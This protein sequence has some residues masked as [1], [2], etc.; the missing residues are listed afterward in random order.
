[1]GRDGILNYADEVVKR[2]VSDAARYAPEER[3][4]ALVARL[5][6]EL[7]MCQNAVTRDVVIDRVARYL[8]LH[9]DRFRRLLETSTTNA[10][11]TTAT[12]VAAT[13][14][15]SQ[16][17]NVQWIPLL[18]V[19]GYIGRELTTL[20]SAEPKTGKTTLLLH[21]VRDWVSCGQRVVWFSEE[22]RSAW[23]QRVERHGELH[24]DS[25]LLAFENSATARGVPFANALREARPD[26]ADS[27]HYTRVLR[28]SR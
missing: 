5:S 18:G 15:A 11:T 9:P 22:S 4:D 24:S 28:H 17:E 6:D 2:V 19:D 20:L 13:E 26:I 23:K 27:G 8:R 12:L 16:A 1:M 14:I 21:A 10:Q 3:L 25:F 7:G